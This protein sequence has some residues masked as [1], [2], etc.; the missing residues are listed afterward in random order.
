VSNELRL[1]PAPSSFPQWT[2]AGTRHSHVLNEELFRGVL[3][4][5]RRRADR[6]NQAFLLL[7]LS[8]DD[9]AA[10]PSIRP[11]AIGALKAAK[12][13]TDVIGWFSG[14]AVLGMI[15]PEVGTFDAP[16]VREIEVRVRRELAMR[17]PPES[18]AGVSSR[19][20]VHPGRA[21]SKGATG[22]GLWP[23]EPLVHEM[24]PPR[25]RVATMKRGLDIVGASGLLLMLAPLFLLIAA[26]MKLTSRGPV[27]FR[28]QRIGRAAKPFEIL[29][30]RTMHTGA[31]HALHR[32][33]TTRLIK[34]SGDVREPGKDAPFKIANDPRVT[35]I[36]RILRKTSFDELPQLWNVLR[37]DMSLVGPRPP[38]QYEVEQY[39]PWHCRRVLEAKPGITGLWQVS[40]RSRTTFDEMV[41]LD[42]RYARTCSLWTDIKILL[43]T[44]AA[45]ISGKGAC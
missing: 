17:L 32:E 23:V 9:D 3:I 2:P 39:E 35:P 33:F 19:L 8:V 4:R 31:D 40:G 42:L 21:E 22:E 11:A 38:I 6:S 36:G 5:E 30:F 41:R 18:L 20:H 16:V 27:F 44:P 25:T 7:L 13:D 12:R 14:R 24:R 34:K 37:G 28:Q 45:V 43:A 29:K 15:A 1:A 26:L 10:N